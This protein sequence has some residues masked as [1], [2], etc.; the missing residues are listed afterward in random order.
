MLSEDQLAEPT[1]MSHIEK[2]QELREYG[3]A[4]VTE[5]L[6]D[7]VVAQ[8]LESDPTLGTAVDQALVSHRGLREDHGDI[9][10][11]DETA[12]VPAVQDDYVNFY[13]PETVNPYIALA[14]AG[15][16]IVTAHGAILHDS[17]G[18]GM[19]GMGHAPTE[20]LSAMAQP[21]VMANV[22]TPSLSQKRLGNRLRAEIGHARADGCP[23]ARFVAMNSGSESVTVA[24]RIADANALSLTG[25][26][27]RH[28]GRQ[29]CFLG[30][31]GGFHGRT[32]RPAQ[33]SDSSMA[34]YRKHLASF[35]ERQNLVTVEPNNVPALQAAFQR[36]EQ[37]GLFFEAMFIEPVMGE[38]RPG[39]GVTR[40]FYDEAR[41][42]TR[43][44]GSLLLVD[45]IQAGIRATGTLSIVD[46][47]GFED[48]E[49]PDM[50]TY[51]KALN[52]GQ[53]PLSVLALTE[54]AAGLYIKGIYGNT[55]TTN[56]RALEVACAVLDH[57]T[58][59]LRENIKARGVEFVDKLKA[60]A[61]E[62]PGAITSV[63]GT[64]LL[65]CAELDP[66]KYDVVGFDGMETFCRKRGI[67]VIH[68]GI[69]ALRFTPHFGL[70]SAEIDVII[71][72]VRQGLIAQG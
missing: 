31:S 16:W 33:V 49:A 15:P 6:T 38:G 4:R 47:P 2:L 36:A 26:G 37:A 32:D 44:H 61:L 29:V 69:N 48:C 40:A 7:A 58:P 46:Y 65:L 43:E 53:Y 30:L 21:W 63:E 27:G 71:D 19:L 56:P 57:L 28:E 68:G 9:L 66:A 12:A 62:L 17:G 25:P 70:T 8:F 59:A 13:A 64:G 45:S 54:R 55:M 34:T 52:A 41:R 60:L 72:V 67:G 42:L 5:G 39:R 10:A 18:Y 14:A 11:M 22:M 20:L 1:S 35:K 51:S 23:F 50:E 24:A 3:G